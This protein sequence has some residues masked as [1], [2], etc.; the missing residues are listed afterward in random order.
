MSTFYILPSRALLGQRFAEF[1]TSVFPGL[2][3][4][5]PQWTDLAEAVDSEVLRHSDVFAVYREDLPEG[6]PL[7]RVLATDFGAGPGDEVVE[8]SLGGRLA[9]LTTRRWRIVAKR[10]AA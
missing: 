2:E 1:L 3:W 9:V 5:R 8:V 4:Q 10:D 7:A 6:T